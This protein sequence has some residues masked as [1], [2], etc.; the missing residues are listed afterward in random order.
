MELTNSKYHSLKDK[1]EKAGLPD[2]GQ[3]DPSAI[4]AKQK[5]QDGVDTGATAGGSSEE[6][7]TKLDLHKSPDF[8]GFINFVYS[9]LKK[10]K[11]KN[12][13]NISLATLSTLLKSTESHSKKHNFYDLHK[14]LNEHLE[15]LNKIHELNEPVDLSH[16]FK[17]KNI[18][19][20]IINFIETLF[21]YE[22][23]LASDEKNTSSSANHKKLEEKVYKNK[24]FGRLYKSIKPLVD[25]V[26]KNQIKIST[27]GAISHATDAF[28]RI[29]EQS[30][31]LPS[32][33]KGFEKPVGDLSMLWSKAINPFGNILQ[34]FESLAKNNIVDA[35]ARFSLIFK[36]NIKEPANLGVPVGTFLDHKMTMLSAENSGYVKK[37][38]KEFDSMGES[39]SYHID[40]YKGLLKNCW[41][42]FK[43]GKKPL[44]NLGLLY[45]VPA[46]GISSLLGTF[47]LKGEVNSTKAQ[48]LGFLRNTSGGIWDLVFNKQRIDKLQKLAIKATGKK[49][50]FKDILKDN[51]IRFMI[52]YLTNSFLDLTM[53]WLKNPKLTIIQS[54]ISNSIYEIANGL[55]GKEVNSNDMAIHYEKMIENKTPKKLVASLCS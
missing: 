54:Q 42:N 25:L 44:E 27:A 30:S 13:N 32:I 19:D 16:S 6:I 24:L 48:I 28:A 33:F 5:S 12:E 4:R 40:I 3:V 43:K 23:G 55:S 11:E 20:S 22:T 46:L 49:A 9:S 15:E 45:A 2:G 37:V 7:I 1:E 52:L 17:E 53:R 51:Q 50:G 34:G 18:K 35:L 36:L 21:Q 14:N 41:D 26:V 10:H 47:L 8:K 29:S 38:K 31:K 39:I